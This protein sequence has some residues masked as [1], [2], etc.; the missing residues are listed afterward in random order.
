[1]CVVSQEEGALLLAE[2]VDFRLA[3]AD[4]LKAGLWIDKLMDYEKPSLSVEERLARE[5]CSSLYLYTP[6][7]GKLR[8]YDDLM[9]GSITHTHTYTYTY[10]HTHTHTH[11]F[12]YD[13]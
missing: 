10:T 4:F 2:R 6:E 8:Q 1:M 5:K 13:R 3:F 11:T 7:K 12:F 9:T